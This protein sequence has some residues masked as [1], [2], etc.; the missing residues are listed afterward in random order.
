MKK[1]LL[2]TLLLPLIAGCN[3]TASSG[4]TTIDTT[5][6]CSTS[7]TA[8]TS[9]ETG[10]NIRTRNYKN[11]TIDNLHPEIDDGYVRISNVLINLEHFVDVEEETTYLYKLSCKDSTDS[12]KT[13]RFACDDHGFYYAEISDTQHNMIPNG[14][15]VLKNSNQSGSSVE[16]SIVEIYQCFSYRELYYSETEQKIKV[17][18]FDHVI[19]GLEESIVN[20]IVGKSVDYK[21]YV[22]EAGIKSMN[23]GNLPFSSEIIIQYIDVS[24]SDIKITK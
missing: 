16:I 20:S 12:F 15:S 5:S 21:V 23:Y 2:F 13:H 17:V 6:C 1:P 22:D 18:D 14:F 11:I 9:V 24:N 8:N 3:S 7:S 10:G 4:N 19:P